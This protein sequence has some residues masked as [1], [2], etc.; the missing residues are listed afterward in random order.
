MKLI[1]CPLNGTRN[2]QEFVFGG[3]VVA[4]PEPDA[5]ESDWSNHVF[6][7]ANLNGVVDEWWCHVATSYWFI[8]RRDR[9]SDEFI[10]TWTTDEYF[11][12]DQHL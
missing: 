1:R 6:L 2:L 5:A 9:A 11:G 10:A 3:D 12:R 8:A 7:E 4:E